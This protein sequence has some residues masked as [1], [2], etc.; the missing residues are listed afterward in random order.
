MS[1]RLGENPV[2]CIHE[3]NGDICGRRASD[4]IARI[5]FMTGRVGDNEF[6]MIRRKETIRH[7]DRNALFAFC[8]QTI[9]K[10]C[11]VNVSP[12]RALSA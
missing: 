3:D 12:L 11:K 6:T 9:D 10:Q 7:I 8:R 1:S 5:L 2:D 4:H